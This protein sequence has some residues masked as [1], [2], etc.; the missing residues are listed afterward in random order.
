MSKELEV[1]IRAAKEAGEILKKGWEEELEII[2]K[3]DNSLVTKIDHQAEEK[4]LEVIQKELPN[5]QILAE[6]SGAQG[7]SEFCWYIDPIDGTTNY[8]RRVPICAVS[9][10]LA[11]NDDVIVGVIYNP[12]TNELYT[13]EKGQ[14][15]Y[16]NEQKIETST[17]EQL[18]KSVIAV[19]YSHDIGTR[20]QVAG[21]KGLITNNRTKR[22]YGSV[23]YEMSLLASGRLDAC[24][25]AGHKPWDYAAGLLL[26][27]EAG[28]VITDLEG[29]DLDLTDK[30]AVCAAN[31]TL[32]QQLLEI[33]K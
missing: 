14:G 5:H 1:A 18:E 4:I 10:A 33:V 15:A 12:F 8:S 19:S 9:I 13:S 6:E 3:A 30:F 11:E 17:T 23:V 21:L 7:S 29:K 20:E 26:V 28:G 22:E 24:Y 16:L 2:S 27:R 31:Q 25:F 32:H